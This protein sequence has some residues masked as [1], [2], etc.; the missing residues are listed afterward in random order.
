MGLVTSIICTILVLTLIYLNL[1]VAVRE[2]FI[3]RSWQTS[4]L[5]VRE[6]ILRQQFKSETE[7]LRFD[8]KIL[9]ARLADSEARLSTTQNRVEELESQ[10]IDLITNIGVKK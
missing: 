6:Q 8:N 7:D 5:E 4:C 9:R 1:R 3:G 2:G 10:L